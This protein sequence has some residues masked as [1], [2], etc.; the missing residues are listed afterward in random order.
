M[1]TS[2]ELYH[3][4]RWDPRFDPA[5]F[6]LGINARG[7]APER[8]PLPMFV[9]GGDIPWHRIVFVEADG[10]V[11]WDR[12]TGLDRIDS[13]QAGR[14]RSRPRLRIPSATARAPFGW[15]PGEGWRPADVAFGAPATPAARL[16]VLTW[17]TLW[18]RYDADKIDTARRRPLLLEALED[19]DADVIALQ[20]V[21]AG[22]LDLILRAPWIRAG[23]TLSTD[24][25]GEDVDTSGLLLLSRLPVREAARFALGP[26]KAVAA[27]TADTA[28]GPI[29]LACT[30]LTSDHSKNG[31][32]R[33]QAELTRIAEILAGVDGDVILLGD[34]NDGGSGPARAL[35]M[36]DAWTEIHGDTDDSATFDPQANPLAAL[37]SLSGRASRLDRV[38]L[39]GHDL[40]AAAARTRGDSPATPDGLFVSDHYG[41]A[42]DVVTD[43]HA[44]E[45]GTGAGALDERPTKRT[46]V[47]WIPPRD[48][49]PAIQE[50]R[51]KHDPGH[52]RWPPH[53]TVLP[54][55]VPESSFEQ[56]APL[57]SAAAAEAAPFAARLQGVRAFPHQHGSTVWLDPAA[58]GAEH[59]AG[60]RRA[61]ERAFPH[62]RGRTGGYTPHLTLG[63][64]R[65][66][67]RHLAGWTA[68]LGGADAH[69]GELVLLSRRKDEPMRPR[70]TVALGTGQVRWLDDEEQAHTDT[71]TRTRAPGAHDP[72]RP[73]GAHTAGGGPATGERHRDAAGET[74]ER[75]R[76]ALP[77]AAVHVTGSRRLGGALP[78][79]DLDLVAAL[80][81]AAEL[82]DVEAK[83]AAALPGATGIRRV[84]GARVPG[85]RLRVGELDLD[86]VIVATS[87]IAPD[88]AVSRRA[89]LDEAS[90]IA[91]SAV[92]DADAVL[93]AT[94][95]HAH[96]AALAREV[97]A[98]AKA[99]GL[100]AAPYGG[101]PGLAWTVLAARTVREAGDLP[102][103][104]LLRHFFGTWAA[105]DWRRPITLWPQAPD[106]ERPPAG[107]GGPDENSGA[108]V[109]IMT[110]TAPVR[111]CSEQVGA[112]G[113]DLLTQELY[114]AWEVTDTAVQ[115]GRDPRPELLS[116]PP[117]HRRHAAWAVVTVRAVRHEEFGVTLGRVRGRT[118]ALLTSLEHAGT[119]EAHAWPRPFETGPG[120]AS[121]A[122]GL[123]RTPPGAAALA[124]IA[125]PWAAGLRGAG[126]EWAPGGEVPT[127]R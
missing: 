8:M 13:S 65:N 116:P 98:W 55:F 91:L 88:E 123:G 26:H 64:V 106:P 99:R 72:H 7:A 95:G 22:L 48:L 39:R 63:T 78:G 47:A 93:A 60:L 1:R 50:I 10:E 17:N 85:L 57:L 19:A 113:R 74:M 33:R 90:A 115:T 38:L 52:Y 69:V 15:R 66:P 21:E 3:R 30:H 14:T 2:E 102:P 59:W 119:P 54:A 109:S 89:E 53:V 104:E 11:V 124:E 70:A 42:V 108:A 86:L 111:L 117:M 77:G 43:V 32:E 49:W 44:G 83:V 126:I 121:F 79:A 23:Y 6:V 37:S 46:A 51:S 31:P 110:P 61:L 107:P 122:V 41:V 34:F 12:T 76:D 67:E 45:R 18:D 29:V 56:A 96:F 75:L 71:Y 127:L 81:G 36:R 20:E 114:R 25:A 103:G 105:W 101:L 82:A 24:P 84:T 28:A 16:R 125:G 94:G 112:G 27:I 68:G 97:K 62:C 100:D 4:I 40:R 87:D 80:P 35:G 58:N 9:P 92:S 118:R 73:A 120:V 5:R